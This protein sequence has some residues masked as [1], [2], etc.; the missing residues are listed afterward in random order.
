MGEP[1][2]AENERAV[3]LLPTGLFLMTSAF[4][5]KR[6]G[7]IVRSVAPCAEEPLLISVSL[8]KGH[9]IDPLIRDSH[10]FAVCRVDP[11]D[12]LLMRKFQISGGVTGSRDQADPFDCVPVETLTTGAPVIKRCLVA[13]D[14]EV[15]RHLDIEADHE[16]FIG[17]VKAARIYSAGRHA[18]ASA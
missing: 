13:L 5:G 15:V 14:C 11:D 3:G 12:K 4:D 10:S 7:V 6:A 8:R 18:A 9:A 2:I 16:L 1:R 17:L